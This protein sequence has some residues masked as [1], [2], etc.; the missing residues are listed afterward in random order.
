MMGR[1]KTK[2]DTSFPSQ[3]TTRSHS[4]A[5]RKRRNRS[6]AVRGKAAPNQSPMK[7]EIRR[8]TAVMTRFGIRSEIS[9]FPNRLLI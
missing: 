7:P 8:L 3:G 1:A 4:G 2:K 5:L 6:P 9:R